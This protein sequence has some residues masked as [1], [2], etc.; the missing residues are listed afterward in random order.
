MNIQAL[1]EDYK[2]EFKEKFPNYFETNFTKALSIV[3]ITEK[4]KLFDQKVSNVDDILNDNYGN[5]IKGIVAQDTFSCN[6][7]DGGARTY[8]VKS[9]NQGYNMRNTSQG[10]VGA[11]L[12][13]GSGTT[14]A[15]RQ[16]TNIENQIQGNITLAGTAG[17]NSGLGQI[18][19]TGSLLATGGGSITE[20]ALFNR[21]RASDSAHH[22]N[23]I[24][25]D[26]IPPASFIVGQTITVNYIILLS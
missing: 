4:G 19:I 23:M 10:G 26:I 1:V 16:D 11:F 2:K 3:S 24:S 20:T 8:F 14:P 7:E 17:Y 12:K 15:T 9:T 5:F 6:R 22:N 18:S 21:W 13:I 25:H